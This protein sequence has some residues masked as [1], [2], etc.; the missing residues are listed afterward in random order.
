MTILSI[1]HILS[2]SDPHSSPDTSVSPE[3]FL[4]TPFSVPESA[5][6]TRMT[7][8]L[9]AGRQG[10]NAST[11]RSGRSLRQSQSRRAAL[12][13]PPRGPDRLAGLCWPGTG[14]PASPASRQPSHPCSS[15]S[16]LYPSSFV[17]NESFHAFPNRR[18]GAPMSSSAVRLDIRVSEAQ[19]A[20]RDG[21]EKIRLYRRLL[22]PFWRVDKK[23]AGGGS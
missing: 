14:G 2:L 9:R 3:R 7:S 6:L 19:S 18:R 8:L 20:T 5:S 15:L 13:F 22:R 4:S 16:F 1:R 17:I 21:V 12:R 23:R 11:A 10:R